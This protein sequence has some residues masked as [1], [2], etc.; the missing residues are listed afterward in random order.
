[1]FIVIV[2][3]VDVVGVQLADHPPKFPAGL[4][5]SWTAV[6][7]RN[8]PVQ[9][10]LELLVELQLIPGGT[11]VTVPLVRPTS[12]IVNIGRLSDMDRVAVA[13]N[14][15]AAAV[16]VVVPGPTPVARPEALIVAT[17]VLLDVQLTRFVQ[18][19]LTGGG[20]DSLTR[21][22]VAIAVNCAVCP[23]AEKVAVVGV[24]VRESNL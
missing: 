20:L 8:E 4:A 11:L 16:I 3:V 1:M 13:D 6:P 21:T 22:V 19:C 5:V 24:T 14:L 18:S 17:A 9:P 7:G 15:L 2:Q 12:W 23:G 10:V